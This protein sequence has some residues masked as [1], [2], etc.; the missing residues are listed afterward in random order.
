MLLI[1]PDCPARIWNWDMYLSVDLA[2]LRFQ[3]PACAFLAMS[4]NKKAFLRAVVNAAA[5][6]R[7]YHLSFLAFSVRNDSF[8]V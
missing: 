8:Q 6:P 5:V 3:S 2:C 1:I 4:E 7:L